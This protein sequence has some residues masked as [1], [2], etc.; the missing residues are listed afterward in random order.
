MSPEWKVV[1]WVVAIV[2]FAV[3]AVRTRSFGWAA[4]AVFTLPF[5]VDTIDQL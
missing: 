2:F 5:L 3:E 4:L 1:C